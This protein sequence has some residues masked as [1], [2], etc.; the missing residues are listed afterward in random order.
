MKFKLILA[1][2]ALALTSIFGIATADDGM[3]SHNHMSEKGGAD[4]AMK[5]ASASAK[6]TAKSS[7]A[8]ASKKQVAKHNH[9][10]EK[11]GP[12][13]ATGTASDK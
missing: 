7:K 4:H 6:A 8:K 11:G 1:A 2:S 12:A 13:H 3:P 9:V 10:A 5:D